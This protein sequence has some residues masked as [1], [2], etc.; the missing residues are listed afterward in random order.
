METIFRDA[1]N[2]PR[3]SRRTSAILLGSYSCV[4]DSDKYLGATRDASHGRCSIDWTPRRRRNS[5]LEGRRRHCR[6][7]K[8]H[9]ATAAAAAAV[10]QARSGSSSQIPTRG[11][12]TTASTH[13]SCRPN[14][15][16][17]T[18]SLT[19]DRPPLATVYHSNSPPRN[20]IPL[21]LQRKHP[22]KRP[23]RPRNHIP[24]PPRGRT[25]PP[26]LLPRQTSWTDR[27]SSSPAI[28]EIDKSRQQ[29]TSRS[30]DRAECKIT[31][32]IKITVDEREATH[33]G[34]S[35]H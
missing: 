16:H 18:T 29:D 33:A 25:T 26:H 27:P 17:F 22:T 4:I 8:R 30:H 3:R 12:T 24:R 1:L 32:F 23:R 13:G 19:I 28:V 2:A 10:C 31:R 21:R 9:R 7:S 20:G 11:R 35:K 34:R 14:I 15:T 5:L 6:Y